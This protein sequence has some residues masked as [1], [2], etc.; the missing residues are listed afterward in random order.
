M[1]GK[2]YIIKGIKRFKDIKNTSLGNFALDA[3]LAGVGAMGVIAYGIKYLDILNTVQYKSNNLINDIIDICT[4]FEILGIS[5]K[6]GTIQ[7]L[8]E[9]SQVT[10]KEEGHRRGI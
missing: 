9:L 6:D 3:S 5:L 10:D 7:Q 2:D 8:K 4:K 1:N